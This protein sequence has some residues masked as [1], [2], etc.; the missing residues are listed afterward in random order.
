M[1]TKYNK[2][3]D[4]N[5]IQMEDILNDDTIQDLLK[6]YPQSQWINVMQE[7]IITGIQSIS[8]HQRLD[9]LSVEDLE[10]IAGITNP[11][12]ES[13]DTRLMKRFLDELGSIKTEITKLDKKIN[14]KTA[15]GVKSPPHYSNMKRPEADRPATNVINTRTQS[16]P[17]NAR[18]RPTNS[19]YT[20]A[21][22]YNI[23][24][25]V[26]PSWWDQPSNSKW[27]YNVTPQ[28][29]Q[30]IAYPEPQNIR[31]PPYENLYGSPSQI[32]RQNDSGKKKQGDR[33]FL[34][35]GGGCRTENASK[36]LDKKKPNK[37]KGM[38]RPKVPE[39]LKNVESKIKEK[40]DVYK[41]QYKENQM[42]EDDEEEA[43]EVEAG[44]RQTN[45][46]KE[47]QL[48]DEEVKERSRKPQKQSTKEVADPPTLGRQDSSLL[49]LTDKYAN[50]SIVNHFSQESSGMLRT[51]E[52][53]DNITSSLNQRV[54]SKEDFARKNGVE[55]KMPSN[56]MNPVDYP[57]ATSIGTD[58]VTNNPGRQDNQKSASISE[59]S[60]SDKKGESPGS[61]N[62]DSNYNESN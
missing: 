48:E 44:Q 10:Q 2:L 29:E 28:V 24:P 38:K 33:H 17:E 41:E 42:L 52:N 15:S 56:S 60:I 61:Y 25:S 32:Y 9:G 58:N 22:Q 21:P 16:G 4:L 31:M 40:I 20:P 23:Y 19:S 43:E 1:S 54:T 51:K 14:Q 13:Q 45:D 5:S 6:R 39:Y 12:P 30:K 62:T 49:K 57:M 50:S 37:V 55:G 27:P 8:H 53:S 34:E 7:M 59:E 47:N 26:R 11:I 46:S 3:F 36:M 18:R 35:R